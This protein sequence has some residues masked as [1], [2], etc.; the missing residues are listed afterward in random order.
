MQKNKFAFTIAE[1]LITLGIIGVIAAYTIPGFIA[2]YKKTQYV[3]G[4]KKAYINFEQALQLYMADEGA[5]ELRQT[6]LYDGSNW[7]LESKQSKVDSVIRK[8]FKVSKSC[9]VN[10]DSSCSITEKYLGSSTTVVFGGSSWYT[11]GTSDGIWYSF[12]LENTCVPDYTNISNAKLRCGTL[13][14][15]INGPAPPNTRGRDHHYFFLIG[16]NGK[17]Y[18][19]YGAEYAK[20]GSG[21]DWASSPAYW[22]N[23]SFYCGTPNSSDITGV[24]GS[25]C[26]A[27]IMEENW[28]MN[29]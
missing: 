26:I 16:Y 15:D 13:A 21:N 4:L 17:L 7:F 25:G 5:T 3:T 9:K 14:V 18:P 10:V 29:Y 28:Q 11:F 6:E 12:Q 20:I 2:N 22:K 1:V 8:Y 23:N 27:R 24:Q 19:Y